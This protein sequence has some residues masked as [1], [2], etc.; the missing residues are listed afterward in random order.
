[1]AYPEVTQRGLGS[2]SAETGSRKYHR[3]GCRAM[4]RLG[5]C[6]SHLQRIGSTGPARD[7]PLGVGYDPSRDTERA[8][9]GELHC[10]HRPY[11]LT[12]VLHQAYIWKH[13]RL[14]KQPQQD[15]DWRASKCH[16]SSTDD[17]YNG[18]T[19]RTCG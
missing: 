5:N 15:Y 18:R 3:N 9:R 7:S 13:F 19:C 12:Y 6:K 2:A 17:S 11:G 14:A 8:R 1:M 4:A 16:R 10:E